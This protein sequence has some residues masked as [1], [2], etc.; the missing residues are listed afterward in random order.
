MFVN[1]LKLEME[2]GKEDII[3]AQ[4]ALEPHVDLGQVA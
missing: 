4:H 1:H 2:R 3:Q